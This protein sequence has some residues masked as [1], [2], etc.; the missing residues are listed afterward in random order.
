MAGSSAEKK[1]ISCMES[2]VPPEE[3][4]LRKR[5]ELELATERA[6]A[7][8]PLLAPFRRNATG[9]ELLLM[10]AAGGGESALGIHKTLKELETGFLGQPAMLK[11]LR[12]RKEERLLTFDEHEKRSQWRVRLAPEVHAA[13]IDVMNRRGAGL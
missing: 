10:L 8:S 11:F 13:L 5:F 3:V 7:R 4:A 12:D 6:I 2:K 9:W 1:V